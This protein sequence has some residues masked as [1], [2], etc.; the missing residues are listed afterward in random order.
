MRKLPMA[1]LFQLLF[2]GAFAKA[3]NREYYQITVYHYK[4]A[5]QEAVIDN[6]LKDALLPALHRTGMHNIGVFKPVAN[7]TATDK[8][9]YVFETIKRP[10]EVLDIRKK[11][12]ADK[13]YQ[14]AGKDYIDASYK[15]PPYV[16]MENILLY[17]FPL[18]ARMEAP[19][20]S[21][22]VS[23]K[24]Y[25]LRSYE[26]PTEKL[27]RNKVTM[28]NAGDEVGLF[29]RLGFN[30]VFYA[31]VI[32]GSKMPNLMYMT[33]FE[34][35]QQREDHWKAF[36]DDPQWK[37]LVAA[38]EYQNNVSHADIILMKATAYSDF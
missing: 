20:L 14:M 26:G 18:A 10:E 2:L 3:E 24:I 1:V 38:P 37:K 23:D 12:D 21:S 25:E 7:D 32:A 13:D 35:M 17:A 22:P 33:C 8:I 34:N 5:A 30:A 31:E 9:I 19:R 27:Y 4:S 6:Y 16:R 11:L 15:T 29:K 36:G 28:F